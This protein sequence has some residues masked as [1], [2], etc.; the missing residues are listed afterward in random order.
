MGMTHTITTQGTV[1]FE[2]FYDNI[3][4]IITADVPGNTDSKFKQL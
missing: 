1:E 2:P 4:Y 3:T